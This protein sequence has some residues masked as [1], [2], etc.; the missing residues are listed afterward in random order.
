VIVT[1]CVV[2]GLHA[3][4]ASTAT[5][6]PTVAVST[7]GV[8]GVAWLGAAGNVLYNAVDAAGMVQ[9]V[10]DVPVVPAASG[11]TFGSGCGTNSKTGGP[12][13]LARPR[14]TIVSAFDGHFNTWADMSRTLASERLHKVK[15]EPARPPS[16]ARSVAYF[17]GV[18]PDPV[19]QE[20]PQDTARAREQLKFEQLIREQL[21]REQLK[22][23]L[24]TGLTP[25]WP[26]G[27]SPDGKTPLDRL[28]AA[29]GKAA[30]RA[31]LPDQFISVNDRD[32]DRYTLSLPGSLQYRISPL[33]T[34]V[35]NMTIAGD[36]TECG[37]NAGCV[38]AAVMSGMLAAHAISGQPDLNAIVGYHHP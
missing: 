28:V 3:A 32:S 11:I 25:V 1:T 9:N 15:A 6:S 13:G 12:S 34:S 7:A 4:S 27:Y 26:A 18:M 36:W 23:L 29:D 20:T 5:G 10:A 8:F 19:K 2:G 17:C 31:A 30:G 21:K 16:V 37:F 38:E 24:R 22:E 14:S 35:A 33:D